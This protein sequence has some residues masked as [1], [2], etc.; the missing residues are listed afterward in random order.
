[1][2]GEDISTIRKKTPYWHFEGI[3]MGQIVGVSLSLCSFLI[4]GFSQ[5]GN[6]SEALGPR[7]FVTPH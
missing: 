4:Y 2:Y 7:E 3:G 1:V 5:Q 6:R